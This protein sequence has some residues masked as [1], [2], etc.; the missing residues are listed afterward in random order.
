MVTTLVSGSKL[1]KMLQCCKGSKICMMHWLSFS[2]RVFSVL[3]LLPLTLTVAR[4]HEEGG[5]ERVT[6]PLVSLQ[7]C[8][9]AYVLGYQT[10][11]KGICNKNAIKSDLA[12]NNSPTKCVYS[13]HFLQ[14]GSVSNCED[15]LATLSSLSLSL[16]LLPHN[17]RFPVSF[18]AWIICAGH[19]GRRGR[20]VGEG[21]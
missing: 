2:G 8:Q 17:P 19:T 9:T 10:G 3:L 6:T 16:S 7:G 20:R 18:R 5:G 15:N 12:H 1:G 14:V 13:W 4:L 21:S 11:I